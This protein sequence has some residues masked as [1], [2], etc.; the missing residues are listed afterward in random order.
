MIILDTRRCP[1]KIEMSC[2]RGY[3][4]CGKGDYLSLEYKGS[5][6]FMKPNPRQIEIGGDIPT[7]A[8]G[9]ALLVQGTLETLDR[10]NIIDN[11]FTFSKEGYINVYW[12]VKNMDRVKEFVE[13][14]NRI[15]PTVLLLK[16]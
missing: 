15:Y 14:Y 8:L 5:F 2:E 11:A 1:M 13:T 3:P 10:T 6:L 7:M 12:I 4:P 16:E 9:T